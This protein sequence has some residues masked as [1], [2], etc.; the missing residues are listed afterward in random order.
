MKLKGFFIRKPYEYKCFMDQN[1]VQLRNMQKLSGR[2]E[3]VKMDECNY[4]K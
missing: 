3:D 1:V 2:S 4:A